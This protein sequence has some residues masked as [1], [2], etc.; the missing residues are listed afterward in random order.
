MNV[1]KIIV[2]GIVAIMMFAC[3]GPKPDSTWS[4]VEYFKY[5]KE[6]YE[7]EDYYVPP[8]PQSK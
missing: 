1:I 6:M 7:D 3:G 5:A 2:T 8:P 4:P